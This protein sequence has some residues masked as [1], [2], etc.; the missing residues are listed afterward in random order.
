MRD[1]GLRLGPLSVDEYLALEE[2][3]TVRH[4]LVAGRVYQMSGATLRH[5][6]IATNILRRLDA[7]T[8]GTACRVYLID[9]KV[10]VAADRIYYPD[11]VVACTAQEQDAMIVDAPCFIVEVTSPSTRRTDRG[12]KLDAYLALASLRG[13]LVVE[14]DRRHV[15][16][17]ER[18]TD[19][20]WKRDE[21]VTSGVVRVACLDGEMSLDDVYAGVEMPSR[22]RRTMRSGRCGLSGLA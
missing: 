11:V 12:E 16:A 21:V 17:Y 6:Q 2:S 8:P 19:T 9:I 5:N 3:S 7:L 1:E 14:Q 4:E 22:V 10:R 13:Y 18:E 15:T 20:E